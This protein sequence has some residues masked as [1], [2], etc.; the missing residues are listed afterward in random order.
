[1]AHLCLDFP[2]DEVACACTD[3]YMLGR[4]LLVAPIVN[5]GQ[6]ERM[7]Y[8]PRGT[9]RNVFTGETHEGRSR[10]N[11]TCPLDEIAVFERRETL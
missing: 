5:E 3:Q 6:T 7:V 1:M 10:L 11:V 8:L 9:W 4:K 2:E